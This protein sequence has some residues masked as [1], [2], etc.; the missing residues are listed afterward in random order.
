MYYLAN[1]DDEIRLLEVVTES[2][3]GNEEKNNPFELLSNEVIETIFKK[4]YLPET[5][6]QSDLTVCMKVCKRWF[7]LI[8]DMHFQKFIGYRR[9]EEIQQQI[10][11]ELLDIESKI[12]EVNRV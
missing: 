1:Y 12:D 8:G 3:E 11:S 4:L 5:P 2:S 9:I 6:E 10:N 7:E